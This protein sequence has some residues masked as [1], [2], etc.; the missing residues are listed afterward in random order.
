MF[1][2]GGS[3][4]ERLQGMPGG[5]T[6][7]PAASFGVSRSRKLRFVIRGEAQIR[8][9]EAVLRLC[10]WEAGSLVSDQYFVIVV[11]C[12]ALLDLGGMVYYS[13]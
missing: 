4:P 11:G 5:H 1:L 12:L 13:L 6:R 8:N 9:F 10:V 7:V 3:S 2:V